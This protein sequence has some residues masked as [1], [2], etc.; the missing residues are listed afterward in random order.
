MHASGLLT[1]IPGCE[2]WMAI[3]RRTELMFCFLLDCPYRMKALRRHTI[4]VQ[5]ELD[6]LTLASRS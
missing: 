6:T 5:L 1:I 4:C 3:D 2:K